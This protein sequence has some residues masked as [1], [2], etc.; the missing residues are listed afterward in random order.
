MKRLTHVLFATAIVAWSGLWST[1]GAALY[2]VFA[3]VFSVAPDLDL[4][5][6]HRKFLHNVFVPSIIALTLYY[7]SPLVGM[8]SQYLVL[9][10]FIGWFSHIFL[11]ALTIKGV[12]LFYPV[13][14]GKISFRL[15]RGD[16][17]FWNFLISLLSVIFV[18]YRVSA[19][20]T[21]QVFSSTLL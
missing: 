4:R 6:G 11:D 1:S 14:D 15:C 20:L 12:Y 9:S 16:S 7:V 18:A 8:N 10:V 19:M 2:T 3:L 21:S 17:V 5:H 13:I